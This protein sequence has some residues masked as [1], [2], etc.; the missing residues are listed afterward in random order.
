MKA[1]T[2]TL[3]VRGLA[4]RLEDDGGAQGGQ[5]EAADQAVEPQLEPPLA[6]PRSQQEDQRG[7]AEDVVDVV[8]GVGHA[9]E[10]RVGDVVEPERPQRVTDDP[11]EHGRGHGQPTGAVAAHGQAAPGAERDAHQLHAGVDPGAEEVVEAVAAGAERVREVREHGDEA[12]DGDP[13]DRLAGPVRHDSVIGTTAPS[14]KR[15]RRDRLGAR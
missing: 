11:G 2:A 13:R 7:V 14:Q 8:G 4:D 6:H 10:R 3:A 15:R 9:R 1:T 12:A 5:R